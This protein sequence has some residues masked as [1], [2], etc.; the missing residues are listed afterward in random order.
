MLLHNSFVNMHCVITWFIFFFS[1]HPLYASYT[2]VYITTCALCTYVEKKDRAL[3][4]YFR[5]FSANELFSELIFLLIEL[6]KKTSSF[7]HFLDQL[8]TP[9][10]LSSFFPSSIQRRPW[11]NPSITISHGKC[12]SI[13]R[14]R[15]SNFK[16]ND[17]LNQNWISNANHFNIPS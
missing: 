2:L 4:L 1:V 14:L 9:S 3:F 5:C 6:G 8:S 11:N 12:W 10:S 15:N 7:P 17:I 13:Y 16:Q